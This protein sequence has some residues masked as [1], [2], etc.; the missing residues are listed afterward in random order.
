M[1]SNGIFQTF[2]RTDLFQIRKNICR[3]RIYQKIDINCIIK[4]LYYI[5]YLLIF[6]KVHYDECQFYF[7]FLSSRITS[8]ILKDP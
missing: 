1:S 7:Y 8:D 4:I 6:K 2:P 3:P 5:L